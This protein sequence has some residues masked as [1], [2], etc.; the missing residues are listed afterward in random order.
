MK[1]KII[2]NIKNFFDKKT[3]IYTIT[4]IVFITIMLIPVDYY[5]TIGG[6]TMNLDKD[7]KITNEKKKNGSINATYVTEL[8][9]NVITYLLSYIIPSFEKE[10]VR[11]VTYKK[12]TKENYEF[13]EKMYFNQ[14]INN[15]IFVAYTNSNKK[16]TTK[17]SDL[18]VIYIDDFATT[19]LKTKDKIIEV[20]N[21]KINDASQIKEIINKKNENDDIVIKVQRDNKEVITKTKIKLIDNEKR[22]GV[23]ILNDY[24][25]ELYPKITFDFSGKQSGPSGGLMLSLSIYNKLND[26][27]IT[28]GNKICGTGTIDKD[29]IVGE[30][31]G[32]KYKLL[33]AKRKKCDIFLVPKEN[34]DE[35]YNT[36]KEKNYKLKLYKV[37]TFN[38][39]LKVLKT[40]QN[41]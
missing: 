15:A 35:A 5:I 27:D 37:E 36:I 14:S 13:R 24:N 2:T 16:I 22:M 8:K 18:Y 34:Y 26:T 31:G 20:D 39:A 28:K 19:N 41:K 11:D 17:S 23:Y 30:I 25:Y 4:L 7:I 40:L 33:G 10:K 12:E 38:D 1:N 21:I 29:G 3:I 32:V 9:G 6:G